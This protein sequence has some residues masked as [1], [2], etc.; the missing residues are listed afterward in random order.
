MDKQKIV[1]LGAGSIGCYLGGLLLNAGQNVSFIG[2]AR[3]EAALAQNGLRL[4]HFTRSPIHIEAENIDFHTEAKI[5]EM[6]DI[7]AL[8]TK[9]QDTEAAAQ[10]IKTH[11]KANTLVVSFQNGVRNPETLKAALPSDMFAPNAI[12]GAI[13]PFNVTPSTAGTFHCGT[14]GELVI[15]GSHDARLTQLKTAFETAGQGVKLSENMIG[16]QWAKMIVN[17]NNGLNVLSGGTLRDGL[18]Q[19]DYRRA[20]ISLVSEALSVARANHIDVGS[21]NG[22]N[23]DSL[24]KVLSLPNFAYRIVM[25][26]IVKI[27]AKARSSMLDDLEAGRGSEINY[28]QGEILRRAKLVKMDAPHNEAVLRAVLQAFEAG[29]SPQLSGAQILDM[30]EM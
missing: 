16:H 8:C 18:M 2:R 20:L 4:T 10:Q 12:L 9:S 26:F 27:D 22:R 6:A 15:E 28:L 13:V 24:I 17:L 1:I 23:P 7:V 21:F 11:C 29:Q 14:E 3:Y 19:R 5:L 30:L 25:Q